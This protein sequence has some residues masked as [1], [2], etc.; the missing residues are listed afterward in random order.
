MTQKICAKLIAKL[1]LLLSAKDSKK[2][3]ISSQILN[4]KKEKPRKC[5]Q[6]ETKGRLI[7]EEKHYT[8]PSYEP[9]SLYLVLKTKLFFFASDAKFTQVF[10]KIYS[11]YSRK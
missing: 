5:D 9:S 7:N 1:L 2:F 11:K 6:S 10:A 8:E 3:R 4:N